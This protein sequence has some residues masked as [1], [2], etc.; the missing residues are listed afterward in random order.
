MYQLFIVFEIIRKA[1]KE[2]NK[3][4]FYSKQITELE[5][6]R[7]NAFLVMTPYWDDYNYNKSIELILNFLKNN[8]VVPQQLKGMKKIILKFLVYHPTK[9]NLKF[10]II[11]SN[12]LSRIK[13]RT[14]I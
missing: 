11:L 9:N 1:F 10:L 2:V 12:I 4:E 14:L 6:L 8:P 5:M 3:L 7:I 13:K